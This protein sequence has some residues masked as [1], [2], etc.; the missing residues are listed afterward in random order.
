MESAHMV[1]DIESV[2]PAHGSRLNSKIRPNQRG[3]L[4][5]RLALLLD[6][7]L[8]IAWKCQCPCRDSKTGM[9]QPVLTM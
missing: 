7:L 3:V 2:W 1:Y 9:S 5:L 8:T 4:M 6:V